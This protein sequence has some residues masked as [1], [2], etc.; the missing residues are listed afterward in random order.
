MKAYIIATVLAVTSIT[1]VSSAMC[2]KK[3]LNSVGMNPSTNTN[4]YNEVKR[5]GSDSSATTTT[6][7]ATDGSRRQR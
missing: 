6:A 4:F 3:F 2:M 1:S 7:S 5:K